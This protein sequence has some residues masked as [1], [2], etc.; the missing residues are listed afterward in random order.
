MKVEWTSRALR[1]KDDTFLYIAPHDVAAAF[2]L[3]ALFDEAA[4]RLAEFPDLGHTGAIPG[5]REILAHRSYRLVY[6]VRDNTVWI[7]T[8]VHT[9]RHWP[10]VG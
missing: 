10:P 8:V 5:T 4:A 7:L 1:D 9:A 3:D 2:R 6:E